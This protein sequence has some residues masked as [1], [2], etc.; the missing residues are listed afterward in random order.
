M[1][2]KGQIEVSFDNLFEDGIQRDIPTD[3]EEGFGVPSV[4]FLVDLFHE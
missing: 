1:R 2:I 3:I 4:G